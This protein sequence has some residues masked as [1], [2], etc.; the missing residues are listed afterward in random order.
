MIKGGLPK[1]SSSR[2]QSCGLKVLAAIK[3]AFIDCYMV[4]YC[5]RSY[6]K[7]IYLLGGHNVT[8]MY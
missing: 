4:A 2:H 1:R 7:D 5:R 3:D 6:K 8:R